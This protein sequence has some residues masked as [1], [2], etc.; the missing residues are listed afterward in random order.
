MKM[1]VGSVLSVVDPS[2]AGNVGSVRVKDV[3]QT[4]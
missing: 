1:D 3:R 2:L 4:P